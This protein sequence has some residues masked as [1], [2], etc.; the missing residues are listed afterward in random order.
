[1]S[2]GYSQRVPSIAKVVLNFS[3]PVSTCWQRLRIINSYFDELDSILIIL[4]V[5]R[6]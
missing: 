4:F 1:M 5:F 2:T 6:V 3:Y